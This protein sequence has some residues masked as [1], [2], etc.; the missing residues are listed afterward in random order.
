MIL[1]SVLDRLHVDLDARLSDQRLLT[2]GE[3]DL[4]VQECGLTLNA[5]W[6]DVSYIGHQN[7][8]RAKK[9]NVGD[10]VNSATALIRLIY[11]HSYL[12]WRIQYSILQASGESGDMTV[13]VAAKDAFLEAL[14]G[15][16]PRDLSGTG[17]NRQGLVAAQRLTLLSA[18]RSDSSI[19]P[20]SGMNAK[21]RNELL[22]RWLYDLGLRR[23]ELLTIRVSDIDFQSRELLV[24]RHPNDPEDPRKRQPN[25]KT[26][27]RL[28]P[29]DKELTDLTYAYIT[30]VRRTQP[31]AKLHDFLF[32]AIGTVAP[33]SLAAVNKVF[34][35]LRHKCPS[36]GANLSPHVLRHTWNDSFSDL[37]DKNNVPAEKEN[38]W[39]SR[40]MGWSEHSGTAAVYTK[41]H[42]QRKAAEA[43]LSLQAQSRKPRE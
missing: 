4:I 13:L 38:K 12:K 31:Q 43:S 6:S 33:L 1:S 8:K 9:D 15:R 29:L 14:S 37:M 2:L 7:I 26:R 28:L 27:G 36:L 22:V 16:F 3:L 21:L 19:N 5:V 34:V 17:G 11:I 24:V 40:L 41:R 39:R 20:W 10:C 18:I 42:D 25:V 35:A 23:G 32:V 30:N